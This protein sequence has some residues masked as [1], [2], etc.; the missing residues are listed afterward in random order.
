MI[1]SLKQEGA[2]YPA[3]SAAVSVCMTILF[4]LVLKSDHANI[5]VERHLEYAAQKNLEASNTL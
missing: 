3:A 2:S 1:Q 4:R 5:T